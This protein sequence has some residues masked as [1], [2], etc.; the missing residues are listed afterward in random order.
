[1]DSNSLG[2]GTI[3]DKIDMNFAH[4]LEVMEGMNLDNVEIE[5]VWNKTI[6][7][8]DNSEIQKVKKI[9]NQS[10]LTVSVISSTL[11]LMCPLIKK[12]EEPKDWE[13][14]FIS[15]HG[16]YSEHLKHLKEC[17]KLC[18]ELE[19]NVIR[20]FGFRKQKDIELSNDILVEKI[21]EKLEKP[22]RLA[23][24]AGVTLAL[25]NCPYSYLPT[26]NLTHKVV[27]AIDSQ[28]LKLIWDPGNTLKTGE[29]PH[30]EYSQIK[31][32]IIHLHFK[33][34]IREEG[35]YIHVPLRKGI[36][37]YSKLSRNLIEDDYQGT[38]SLEPG[39]EIEGS[40]EKAVKKDLEDL[41]LILTDLEG[42]R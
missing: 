39:Y 22:V 32:D 17:F 5:S 11:F 4:A 14:D 29:D 25:E 19:S 15:K 42:K 34:R 18:K 27:S 10:S 33:N 16:S 35:E 31:E 9:L 24:E 36:I 23:E 8:I 7:D 37:D 28:A 2:I 1:M 6:E 3:S 21:V 41:R 38:I 26:G 30:S 20:I 40:K 13:S 12:G